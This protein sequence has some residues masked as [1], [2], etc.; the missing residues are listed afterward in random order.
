M[1]SDFINYLLELLEPLGDVRSRKMFGGYGIYKADLM[2]A[3]VADDTLYLKADEETR[4][5]F[6]QAGLGP[7]LYNKNGKELAM[8]YY[9]APPETLEDAE[10]MCEWA[11]RAYQVAQ[12]AQQSKRKLR[13]K[14]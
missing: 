9:E 7:F 12:R 6:E 3:L 11:E 1:S 14:K 10:T 13:A 2:F 5:H 4:P 8:S